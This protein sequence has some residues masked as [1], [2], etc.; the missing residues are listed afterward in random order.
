MAFK[1]DNQNKRKNNYQKKPSNFTT[2]LSVSDIEKNERGQAYSYES[3][4]DVLQQLKTACNPF[5][6]ISVPV[7]MRRVDC[8]EVQEGRKYN[9][10]TS[11]GFIKKIDEVGD[12]ANLAS[13][14]VSIYAAFADFVKKMDHP[15]VFAKCAVKDGKM[16]CIHNFVI[17]EENNI[18]TLIVEKDKK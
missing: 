16:M 13:L 17:I 12:E 3:M 14:E 2:F 4:S 5:E 18:E 9:G 6:Y 1:N 11:V 15:M 10:I 8:T 7:Y